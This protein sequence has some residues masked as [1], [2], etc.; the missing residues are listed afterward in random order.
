MKKI[1]S[2]E[3]QAHL[4]TINK[5]IETMEEDLD[6]T[7]TLVLKTLKEG[8]KILLCGNGGSAADAHI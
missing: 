1:I 3:F 8:N 2:N 5:V 7:S 4:E 6:K